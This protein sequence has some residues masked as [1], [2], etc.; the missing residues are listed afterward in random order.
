MHASEQHVWTE[1]AAVLGP[2]WRFLES[3]V[4]ALVASA[5]VMLVAVL[6]LTAVTVTGLVLLSQ[7]AS[8]PGA[9]AGWTRTP[10]ASNLEPTLV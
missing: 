1:L 6:G 5:P 2:A 9:R 8:G 4:Q 7:H 10:A 3:L